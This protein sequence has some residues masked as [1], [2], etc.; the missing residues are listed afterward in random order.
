MNTI[1]YPAGSDYALSVGRALAAVRVTHGFRLKNAAKVCGERAS[2]FKS[3]EAGTLPSIHPA[4]VVSAIRAM[5]NE[6][7]A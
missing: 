1:T 2:W 3:A 7:K 6:R 4:R 5:N